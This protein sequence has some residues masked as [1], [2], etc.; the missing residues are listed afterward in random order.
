MKY[1]YNKL[2]FRLKW[3]RL[4]QRITQK[5]IADYLGLQQQSYQLRESGKRP[6]SADEII[7]LAI[8]L[9]VFLSDYTEVE[10]EEQI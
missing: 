1:T 3:E 2:L 7:K 6:F 9:K 4:Q 8:Y 5:Q 10:N